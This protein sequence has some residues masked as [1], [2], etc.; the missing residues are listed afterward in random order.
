[1]AALIHASNVPQFRFQ[2]NQTDWLKTP[3]GLRHLSKY[4]CKKISSKTKM[5]IKKKV[6]EDNLALIKFRP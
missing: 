1:M 6:L 2:C 4:V 5:V 3:T